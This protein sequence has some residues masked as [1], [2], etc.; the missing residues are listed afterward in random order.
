MTNLT[1]AKL[2]H[3]YFDAQV[4]VKNKCEKDGSHNNPRLGYKFFAQD[5]QD[6]ISE[7]LENYVEDIVKVEVSYS[8][9]NDTND[10]DIHSARIMVETHYEE[11]KDDILSSI[12]EIL[13]LRL[14][15]LV[16]ELV[17]IKK[18]E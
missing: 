5:I 16:Q 13:E 18:G 9:Q 4:K 8:G 11:D 15:E 10:L 6:I 7:D 12:Q 1:K 17:E 3:H 2:H 14:E